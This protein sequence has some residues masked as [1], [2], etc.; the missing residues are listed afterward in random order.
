VLM[1][2]TPSLTTDGR[3]VVA[4][5]YAKCGVLNDVTMPIPQGSRA[6]EYKRMDLKQI[7]E[8]MG[9]PFGLVPVFN[10]TADEIG[11]AIRRVA[12]DPTTK[13][14]P[15][16][17]KL[18]RQRG[19]IMAN[20]EFGQP[21]FQKG[22]DSPPVQNLEEGVSPLL[23]VTPQFNAQVYYSHVTAITPGKIGAARGKRYSEVN[24]HLQGVVRPYVYQAE[25]TYGADSVV[26]AKAKL[27]R[28]FG[29]A[30]QWVVAVAGW[31]MQNG[32][33]WLPNTTINLL[34]PSAYIYTQS[35]FLVRRVEQR[36]AADSETTRLTVVLP[37]S[38][39]GEI[40]EV[41]P[42]A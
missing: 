28:M 27:G 6:L 10:V 39:S 35:R 8:A 25:D 18:A 2:P 7:T 9:A 17:T 20:D 23:S 21:L 34:A 30:M 22:V 29:N 38:Y 3:T 4:D 15:F 26:A 36:S 40:P 5:G 13:I 37:G 24:P 1:N 14:L 31:T 12:I 42:W 11:P 32:A 19:L 33:V 16:W 41:L